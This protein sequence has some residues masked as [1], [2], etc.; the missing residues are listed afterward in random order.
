[1]RVTVSGDQVG[2]FQEFLKIPDQWVRDY[3][4]LRSRNDLLQ[5]IA[6][7]L[8]VLLLAV[9]LV[10]IARST[11]RRGIHWRAVL[12]I[13]AVVGLLFSAQLWNSLP[14]ALLQL[15]SNFP[16]GTA[17][18]ILAVFFLIAGVLVCL[19]TMMLAASGEPLY[20]EACPDRDRKS[21]V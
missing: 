11:Q 9:G 10:V 15:P 17:V 6:T 20:R 4:T 16:Y 19:Y 8:Y 5:Y 7:A 18:S 13:G 2:E 3:D 14:Q 12:A 1:M 21:V